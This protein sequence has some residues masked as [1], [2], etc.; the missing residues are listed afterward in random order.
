MRKHRAGVGFFTC[1]M[2]QY[3]GEGLAPPVFEP[4]FF[5][6]SSFLPAKHMEMAIVAVSSGTGNCQRLS[7]SS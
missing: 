4:N 1:W 6:H 2:M 7:S 5:L 3:P